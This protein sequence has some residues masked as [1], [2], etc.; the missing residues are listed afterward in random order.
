MDGWVPAMQT[1]SRI[2]V[3]DG[4]VIPRSQLVGAPLAMQTMSA[5][6]DWVTV[7]H[8]QVRRLSLRPAASMAPAA[9]LPLWGMMTS[10]FAML[11]SSL[12]RC[13]SR[14][15]W[16]VGNATHVLWVADI[17]NSEV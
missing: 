17:G 1:M 7:H 6:L 13:V 4:F 3:L 9:L 14:L 15:V 10:A 11:A 12:V 16:W 2:L 5:V 8:H